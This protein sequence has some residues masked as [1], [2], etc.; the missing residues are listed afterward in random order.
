MY[1][2]R[3]SLRPFYM[4]NYFI[5]YN[6]GKEEINYIEKPKL[7]KIDRTDRNF[8]DANSFSKGEAILFSGIPSERMPLLH[9]DCVHFKEMPALADSTEKSVKTR[10]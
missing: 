2:K 5:F 1:Q 7:M 9:Q 3:Q 10:I 6:L 8:S 4:K